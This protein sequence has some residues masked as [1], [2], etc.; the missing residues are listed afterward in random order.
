MEEAPRRVLQG[1]GDSF[2]LPSAIVALRQLRCRYQLIARGNPVVSSDKIV[3]QHN[4]K[5]TE[6]TNS[7]PQKTLLQSPSTFGLDMS[8]I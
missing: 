8:T 5:T 3:T 2:N 6:Q 7:S 4:Y 1:V